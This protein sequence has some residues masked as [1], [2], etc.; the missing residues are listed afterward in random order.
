MLGLTL[1]L[2]DTMGT[3]GAGVAV[4]ASQA[5]IAVAISVGLWRTLNGDQQRGSAVS[6]GVSRR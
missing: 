5:I 2:T 6:D 1:V 4:A 3:L